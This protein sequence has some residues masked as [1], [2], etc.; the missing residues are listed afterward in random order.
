MLVHIGNDATSEEPRALLD[1]A[2]PLLAAWE[3]ALQAH[4]DATAITRE[5]R[6]RE[7]HVAAHAPPVGL[8]RHRVLEAA[9]SH[10]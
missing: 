8:L 3:R 5:D 2:R 1:V 9:H 7:R 10:R 6:L 4:V